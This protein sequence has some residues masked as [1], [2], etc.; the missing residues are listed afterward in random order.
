MGLCRHD[1]K[2][3]RKFRFQGF[4][5]RGMEGVTLLAVI[6]SYTFTGF[7]GQGWFRVKIL[8]FGFRVWGWC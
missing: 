8:D 5:F 3:K 4:R 6:G 7:R 2:N 1:G